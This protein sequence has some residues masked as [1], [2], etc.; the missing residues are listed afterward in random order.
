VIAEALHS[1]VISGAVHD[2]WWHT[3]QMELMSTCAFVLRHSSRTRTMQ[4]L[5][6]PAAGRVAMSCHR[7]SFTAPALGY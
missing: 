3:F 5:H 4:T 1:G 6:A 2:R 7:F